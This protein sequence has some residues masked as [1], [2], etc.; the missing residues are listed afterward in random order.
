MGTL[1]RR[2]E[3]TPT[4]RRLRAPVATAR[5]A[6]AELPGIALRVEADELP[7][8]VGEVPLLPGADVAGVLAAVRALGESIGGSPL[9]AAR[10]RLREEVEVRGRDGGRAAI[11]IGPAGWGL[12]GAL[13]RLEA[14]VAGL[15]LARVALPGT[16]T[17]G[18]PL[19]AVRTNA[20]AGADAPQEL[21]A[22]VDA[23]VRAGEH[24]VKL[25]VGAGSLAA[26][27]ARVAAARAAGPELALRLDAN[28]AWDAAEAVRRARAFA[29]HRPEWIEQPVAAHDLAG[30]ARVRR[31]SPVPI[32]ADES[33]RDAAGAAAVLAAGAA[34]ALVLKPAALG[35]AAV[36]ADL[37]ERAEGE[38]VAVVLSSL[39]DGPASLE[40]SVA[41]A[42]ALGRDVVH[43][44]GTG[45]WLEAPGPAPLPRRGRIEVAT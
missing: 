40:M 37:C 33:A 31:S 45:G 8:G 15:A 19:P 22:E 29:V 5:G 23:F 34:D 44:L 20:L 39:F 36:T 30:L 4:T 27:L 18:P 41:L 6:L 13:A 11:A 38:G 9:D 2:L 24:T 17:S 25:K 10:A 32:A 12:D 26:D 7:P 21:A 28:G 14:R 43:G 42:A 3:A 35:P 16:G 1:V